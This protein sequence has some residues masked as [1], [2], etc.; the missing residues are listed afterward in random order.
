MKRHVRPVRREMRGRLKGLRGCIS[1]SEPWQQSLL[2]G[3]PPRPTSPKGRQVNRLFHHPRLAP[4][5]K[6]RGDFRTPETRQNR[7]PR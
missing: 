4:N 6:R 5:P 2:D 3:S 7:R 1:A